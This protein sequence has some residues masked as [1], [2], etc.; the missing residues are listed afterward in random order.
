MTVP[1]PRFS[2]SALDLERLS[3]AAYD[4]IWVHGVRLTIDWG[5][6]LE[7]LRP[8]YDQAGELVAVAARIRPT[9]PMRRRCGGGSPPV[10]DP[11]A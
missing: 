1:S 9:E 3:R 8:L 11:F 6:P 2:Q 5:L 7:A 10:R 4:S